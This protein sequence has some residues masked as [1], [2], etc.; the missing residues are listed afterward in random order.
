[1]IIARWHLTAR[2]GHRDAVVALLGKWE[3][4]VGQRIGWRPGSVRILTG[5]LGESDSNIEFEVRMDNL[6]DLEVAWSNM[7]DVPYHAQHMKDLEPLVAAGTTRW[8][9]M[10]VQGLSSEST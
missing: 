7:K 5:M 9:V 6:S 10:R 8:T 2:F 1:M 3:V 4:D